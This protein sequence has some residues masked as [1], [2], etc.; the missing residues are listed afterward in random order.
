MMGGLR[1]TN[2]VLGIEN[3]DAPFLVLGDIFLHHHKVIFDKDNNRMGFLNNVKHLYL[4]VDNSLILTILNLMPIGLI[5]G[6]FLILFCRKHASSDLREGLF[7]LGGTS[8]PT[9]IP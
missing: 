4:Y 7:E 9:F 8:Q 5:T 1:N 6:A 3:L 2:C